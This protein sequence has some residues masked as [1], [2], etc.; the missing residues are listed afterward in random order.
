MESWVAT[1]AAQIKTGIGQ[2]LEDNVGSV[3]E[4][5][6]GMPAAQADPIN[7]DAAATAVA[8]SMSNPS[9]PIP[10]PAANPASGGRSR[11]NAGRTSAAIQ[12]EVDALMVNLTARN[13]TDRAAG[14]SVKSE[15]ELMAEAQARVNQKYSQGN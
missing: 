12:R 2:V 11:S 7:I 3:L 1:A 15:Q 4:A 9:V 14:R 8:A 10:A 13:N 6:P 5:M